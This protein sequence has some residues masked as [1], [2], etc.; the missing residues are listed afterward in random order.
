MQK[1]EYSIQQMQ[2]NHEQ[3]IKLKLFLQNPKMS[4]EDK[5]ESMFQ[6]LLYNQ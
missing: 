4:E 6:T 1:E 3:N 5:F 2:I